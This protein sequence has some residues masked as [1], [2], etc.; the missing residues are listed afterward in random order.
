VALGAID[1]LTQAAT[2]CPAA[3]RDS[4]IA[5]LASLAQDLSRVGN[6]GVSPAGH[7]AMHKGAHA[8]VA[9]ATLN[10]SQAR[11]AL[12]GAVRNS[13]WVARM[14][15]A[16]AAA[17]LRDSNAL[18]SM[19]RDVH[20][21][22]RSAAIEGLRRLLAHS[23]DSIYLRA[24]ADPDY[25]VIR[26]SAAGL[27]QSTATPPM[28]AAIFSALAAVTRE[29]RETSRDARVALMDRIAELG[30]APDSTQLFT[31]L[32]DYDPTIAER[33]AQILSRWT[34]RSIAAQ[35]V[36][37]PAVDGPPAEMPVAPGTRLRF[38]RARIAGGGTIEL[39]LWPQL[40]PYTVARLVRLAR[41]GY[42]DG[43]TFHRVAPNFVL[44][45]GS[46]GANEYVG[47][48]PFMRDEIWL[49][50][51]ERGTA[52]ISTRGRDTGDAQLFFNT[53]DNPR[54]D[55]D[56]TVFGRVVVGMAVVDAFLEGDVIERVEV[57]PPR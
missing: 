55:F 15:A 36:R 22:V 46:P 30:S 17:T 43:L 49:S 4:A 48:G 12:P 13:S 29:R 20:G 10:P 7:I 2:N 31:Y 24:I 21:N 26:V 53:V 32:R 19:S 34:G 6:D 45:G 5:A 33:A 9:L 35:P 14:Y 1:I 27:A 40:A 47:D 52:G 39:E 51:H 57:I 54:L 37:L 25:N 3:A 44:Q 42:Y 56:Y 16:R 18:I 11:S 38:T 8:I 23:A 41:A 28:R 50:S